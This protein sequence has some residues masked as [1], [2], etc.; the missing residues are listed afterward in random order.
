LTAAVSQLVAQ[1]GLCYDAGSFYDLDPVFQE[2]T[3]SLPVFLQRSLV[4]FFSFA[5]ALS[6]CAADAADPAAHAAG[7]GIETAQDASRERPV[8]FNGDYFR[9]YVTDF[10]DIVTS[11]ARWDGSDWLTATLVAGVATGL[12][13]NDVK[14]MNWAQERKTTTANDVG[15]TVTSF[16][17]GK[18]TPM[19]I[20]GM[21][22]YGYAAD[23]GKARKT[24]LLSVE[25]FVLTG[26]FVQTLKHAARRHRPNTG[27]PSR[28]FDGPGLRNPTSNSSFP[29]GH[30]SSAFAVAT[31]IASEYDNAVVPALAYG[32]AAITALNRVM[33]NAHWPSD[34]FVGAAIGYFTGKAIV[35]SHRKGDDALTLAPVVDGD[36]VGMLVT[37]RF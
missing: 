30:A 19:I 36:S 35:A 13:E 32:T 34:T 6:A 24:A 3:V 15:D 20:G 7:P 17:H 4:C 28:T 27:D 2:P 1:A 29:S 23:D 18:Y 21:Y 5:F 26:I 33:H 37:R 10:T 16:G 8:H 25:S 9:G 22:V 11:P 31:V 12:Y 14:I